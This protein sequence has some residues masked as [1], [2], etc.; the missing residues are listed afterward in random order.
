MNH[1]SATIAL[2]RILAIKDFCS[3]QKPVEFYIYF[4]KEYFRRA[5]TWRHELKCDK[6][7]WPFFDIPSYIEPSVRADRLIVDEMLEYVRSFN[8]SDLYIENIFEWYLHWNVLK[9]LSLT[10]KFSSLESPYEPLIV[11]YEC[12]VFL[13]PNHGAIGIPGGSVFKGTWTDYLDRPPLESPLPIE[14]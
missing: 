1:D 13:Y 6:A 10:E 5:S 14:M 2:K 9:S 8:L 7:S 12:G 3:E 4:L 11:M